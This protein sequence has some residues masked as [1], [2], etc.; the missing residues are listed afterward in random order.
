MAETLVRADRLAKHYRG[1]KALDDC[2]LEVRRGEVFGLLGPNGSGKTTLL[3]LL[4]G[5]LKPT[6]GAAA[7]AGLDCWRESVEV[8]RRLTYMPAEARLF[9]HMRGRDLLK[10]FAD[11]HP[12]GD[13]DRAL[14]VADRL[15]LDLARRAMFCSSG[16][17]QKIAFAA[18]ISAR[19]ELAI[20]D[21]PTANL[22]PTARRE[23]LRLVREA[24]SEGRTVIFS[25][26]VLPEVEAACDRAAL[27]RGGQ[28]AEL[29]DVHGVRRQRRLL[30]RTAGALPPLP[31]ALRAEV[32]TLDLG[33]G[34][35]E[36]LTPGELSPLLGWLAGLELADLRVEPVGLQAIYDRHHPPEDE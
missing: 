18:T 20:L 22:D 25:S 2:T 32:E 19:A 33:A 13:F 6:H 28:L 15:A 17:R 10:F 36:L 21:E 4:L 26:H 9:A 35:Y 29:I 31:P 14:R 7:V 16:M 11:I 3:R 8:H 30:L 34:R 24:R 1:V 5:F 27:L 23:T 12:Q